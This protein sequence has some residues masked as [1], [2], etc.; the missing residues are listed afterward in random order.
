MYGDVIIPYIRT[1]IGKLPNSNIKDVIEYS[2]LDGKCIR[3][4]V[5]KYIMNHYSKKKI[6]F[7]NR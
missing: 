1:Y 2:L 6:I 4:Y 5:V 3:G 7:L